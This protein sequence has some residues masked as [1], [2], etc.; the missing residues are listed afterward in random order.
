MNVRAVPVDFFERFRPVGFCRCSS[1][2][3]IDVVIGAASAPGT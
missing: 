1:W 2:F 3:I